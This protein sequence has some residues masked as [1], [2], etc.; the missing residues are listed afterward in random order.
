MNLA[1]KRRCRL[2]I[3][4]WLILAAATTLL[5]WTTD[6]DI[7]AAAW[8]Y[9]PEN[10]ENVWPD[11]QQPFWRFLFVSASPFVMTAVAA[12]LLVLLLSLFV[13]RL[14]RYRRQALYAVLVIALGPGLVVNLIFKDHWGR[15][16]P[17]HIAEF[18][19]QYQY[20]PPLQ[21]GHTPDKS[22]VCG[23]CSVGYGFF[24]LYFL[25][26]HYRAAYFLLTLALA[27]IMGLSRMAAGGHFLSDVIW[28][29]YLVFLV[30][31]L[32]YYGWYVRG[33]ER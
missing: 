14:R 3:G 7:R 25:A 4:V 16:R 33:A 24:I 18:G 21:I 15:P 20:I 28:S 29:G 8:F 13:R 9:H 1:L 2:E 23:H 19:G 22:F 32:L 26:P 17:M 6:L 11:R 12:A 10:P 30:A 27:W 5:F 31:F